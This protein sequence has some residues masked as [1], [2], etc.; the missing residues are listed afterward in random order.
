MRN[1]EPAPSTGTLYQSDKDVAVEAVYTITFT[2]RN[3]M[4]V[5]SAFTVEYP[6]TVEPAEYLTTSVVWY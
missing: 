6:W 2:T 5:G 4:P 1:R 3:N